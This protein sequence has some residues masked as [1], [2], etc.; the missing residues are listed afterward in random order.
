MFSLQNGGLAVIE[1]V[2]Q[3]ALL[4]QNAFFKKTS[5]KIMCVIPL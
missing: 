1:D 5:F 2:T 4:D 3:V